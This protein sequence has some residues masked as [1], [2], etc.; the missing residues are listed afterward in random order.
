MS[1]PLKP[2]PFC[3][4]REAHVTRLAEHVTSKAAL[5]VERLAEALDGALQELYPL[6]AKC[7]YIAWVAERVLARLKGRTP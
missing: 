6:D 2:C 1:E 4:C 7:G 5:T 3:G